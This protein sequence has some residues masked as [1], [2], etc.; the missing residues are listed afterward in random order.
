M[1]FFIFLF[2]HCSPPKRVSSKPTILKI[3]VGINRDAREI[4]HRLIEIIFEA[5][6]CS[7]TR[8]DFN[9]CRQHAATEDIRSPNGGFFFFFFSFFSSSFFLFSTSHQKQN[10]KQTTTK[11]RPERERQSTPLVCV[12][13]CVW[14]CLGVC[15]CVCVC[16]GVCVCV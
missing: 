13:V 7:E 9:F 11:T 12:C 8:S 16:G 14:V 10:N 4:R 5:S 1:H 3:L 2:Y 15:V 6:F